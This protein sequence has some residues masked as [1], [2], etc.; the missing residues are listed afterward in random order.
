MVYTSHSH[1]SGSPLFTSKS[2][3]KRASKTL[4]LNTARTS[5][6]LPDLNKLNDSIAPKLDG[7][8]MSIFSNT[9]TNNHEQASDRID[10]DYIIEHFHVISEENVGS[11]VS[12]SSVD[13]RGMQSLV[14]EMHPFGLKLWKP[15]I[16]I[17]KRTIEQ[18]LYQDTHEL[19]NH[20]ISIFAKLS[21]L[22]WLCT[23]GSVLFLVL[24][25]IRTLLLILDIF[26][27]DPL[28][29]RFI[30][31]Y[32]N[33]A[34][35]LLH[36]F[37]KVVYLKDQ[38]PTKL[39]IINDR[40][41]EYGSTDNQH[42]D[43]GY[44]AEINNTEQVNFQKSKNFLKSS[45]RV[46]TRKESESFKFPI[47][48]FLNNVIVL[49]LIRAI[50]YVTSIFLHLCVFPIPLSDILWNVSDTLKEDPL[51][52]EFLPL[53]DYQQ[54]CS[55]Q[56]EHTDLRYLYST[57]KV[58]EKYYTKFTYNGINIIISNLLCFAV[59]TISNYYI[60]YRYFNIE[61]FI[62]DPILFFIMCL[63]SM[64]PLS[65][66][67][68][69]SIVS[70]SA[71][72]SIGL[73]AVINAFFSSIVE[74]LMYCIA[75]NHHEGLIV[76]GAIIGSIL[77]SILLL[78]GSAMC[79]GAI[80]KKIQK[81]NPASAGITSIL[82]IFSSILICIPSIID[83]VYGEYGFE[84]GSAY[85]TTQRYLSTAMDTCHV[86]RYEL[87]YND[88]YRHKIVHVSQLSSVILFSAY[89]IGLWYTLKTHALIV[90]SFKNS[91]VSNDIEME[92]IAVPENASE[93]LL[94]PILN[95]LEGN[96]T[97]QDSQNE[98]NR[99]QARGKHA[100]KSRLSLQSETSN[101]SKRR[102]IFILL[103][104]TV[105]Y[106][107]IANILIESLDELMQTYSET[108]HPKLV[109]LT[110]IAL[111][112]NTTEFVNAISFAMQGN[113]PLSMEI[114]S[115]YSLQVCL[116]Q[117]PALVLYSTIKMAVTSDKTSINVRA[118]LFS[119]VFPI[120]DIICL[121]T[122]N[123]MF[124]YIFSEGDSN[125]FK[126]SIIIMLYLILIPGFYLQTERT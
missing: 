46:S 111:V 91:T 42:R 97:E 77:G 24:M 55:E 103:V 48:E 35:Y 90:W 16:Y 45:L 2:R 120:W 85:K 63:V 28:L 3:D 83:I 15:A 65:F 58:A 114:G 23:V 36:P 11:S 101:W 124:T 25:I 57:L 88:F 73:S 19:L 107:I 62:T 75:L 49:N 8:E 4:Y 41:K 6:S 74:I 82:L 44:G 112:P 93:V 17:K 50:L 113:M 125:Y 92:A 56:N 71:K 106:A 80:K 126:G 110:V 22:M 66:Y 1:D 68:G 109:G 39:L 31:C 61:N 86:I 20:K 115:A 30:D 5:S 87:K 123:F 26:V 102:S 13:L 84:C 59:L 51:Q 100:H 33:F 104:S 40:R 72:S 94:A 47:I 32:K 70:I 43:V 60:L 7:N 121:L 78:P 12:S 14:N 54:L 81:Y 118:D 10:A 38:R 9:S 79:S 27:M 98:L 99:N 108:I 96:R 64:I 18:T 76:E 53:Q 37:G 69:Q 34:Y 29:Q 95:D 105:V 119:M 21:N 116:L 67:I 52:L 89:V 117:I 122:S